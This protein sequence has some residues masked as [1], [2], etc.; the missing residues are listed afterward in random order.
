[1][2]EEKMNGKNEKIVKTPRKVRGSKY[3][4]I[5]E[6]LQKHDHTNNGR[7]LANI[8]THIYHDHGCQDIHMM[9]PEHQIHTNNTK[10][11]Y[12]PCSHCKPHNK[13]YQ[14]QLETP[15]HV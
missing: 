14:I 7:Y 6:W 3:N 15:I 1:M 4:P 10:G 9:K 12:R 13:E 5:Q 2:E 11:L 8:N